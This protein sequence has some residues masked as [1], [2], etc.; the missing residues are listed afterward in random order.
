MFGIIFVAKIQQNCC[1]GICCGGGARSNSGARVPDAIVI[2]DRP[3]FTVGGGAP[4]GGYPSTTDFDTNTTTITVSDGAENI[5][6]SNDDKK[7][8]G[9]GD[10]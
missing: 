8:G 2:H 3:S 9:G 5:N 10:W 6:R 4:N 1:C 7:T